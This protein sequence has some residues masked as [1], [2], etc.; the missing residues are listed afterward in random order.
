MSEK[1]IRF[2]LSRLMKLS[3]IVSMILV[4]IQC[5]RTM[6]PEIVVYSSSQVGD[7]LTKGPGL[8]FTSDKES[9]VAVIKID[10]GIRFQ[11]ID[12]FGA[13]FNETGMI[14]LNSLNAEIR[15]SV[16]KMLFDPGSG[17]GYALMKSP[18]A[19]CDFA[20]AGPWYTYNDTPGDTLME[21]FTIGRDLG[22]SGLVTYIKAASKFGSF[23]IESPIYFAPDW[24]YYRLTAKYLG[25]IKWQFKNLKL[26]REQQLCGINISLKD[27]IN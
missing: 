10:E 27:K 23:E 8:S 12:G 17:A 3:V 16:F 26:I 1:V 7:R 15:D 19:A 24:M 18:I 20:S 11:K 14:C 4:N 6:G 2:R 5:Q 21:H 25:T 13:T 9:S 22:P